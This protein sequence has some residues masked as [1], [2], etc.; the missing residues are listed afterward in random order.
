[1]RTK[2]ND[3]GREGDGLRVVFDPALDGGAWPGPLVDREAA[4]GEAWLGPLGTIARL[5][6]ELGLGGAWATAS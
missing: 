6:T 2:M 5:E 4:S 1:M 3:V